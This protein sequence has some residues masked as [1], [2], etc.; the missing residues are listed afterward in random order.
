MASIVERWRMNGDMGVSKSKL[1]LAFHNI[2]EL[3]T[4][5]PPLEADTSYQAG[6][7]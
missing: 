3:L 5:K 2:N 6:S 4:P 1:E 7:H